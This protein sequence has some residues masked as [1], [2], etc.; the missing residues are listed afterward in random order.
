MKRFIFV[1][2]WSWSG[3]SYAQKHFTLNDALQHVLKDSP[4]VQAEKANIEIA[5]AAALRARGQLLPQLNIRGSIHQ[6]PDTTDVDEPRRASE[7]SISLAQ[8]L[9]YGGSR[10]YQ[11]RA[12]QSMLDARIAG[13]ASSLQNIKL[14]L[15]QTYLAILARMEILEH[16]REQVR[17]LKEQVTVVRARFKAGTAIRSDVQQAEARLAAAEGSATMAES[18]LEIARA[19]LLQYL[20]FE[21]DAPLVWPDIPRNLPDK[22]E[23]LYGKVLAENPLLH[24]SQALIASEQ[25]EHKAARGA[26]FPEFT[27]EL[28]RTRRLDQDDLP[29]Q[30]NEIV[31]GMTLNLFNGLQ[32]YYNASQ[33]NLELQQARERMTIV[34][35]ELQQESSEIFSQF[36]AAKSNLGS[37]RVAVNSAESAARAFELEYKSGLRGLSDVLNAEQ[38]VLQAQVSLIQARFEY[39]LA[40]YRMQYVAGSL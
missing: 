11:W 28:R 20:G 5:E 12:A 16:Q 30:Q 7:Y 36:L 33:Q 8:P 6:R 31:L 17:V 19:Q 21:P 9:F 34:K 26:F 10:F 35:R 38:D 37:L 40:A 24:Q 25:A 2:I 4:Y 15:T 29:E 13:T 27:A 22:A 1:L 23:V 39:Y 14:E 3:A 32:S 18:Q